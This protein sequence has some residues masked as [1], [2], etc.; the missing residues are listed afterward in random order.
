[1]DDFSDAYLVRYGVEHKLLPEL[2]LSERSKFTILML[3]R[4]QGA[5][6]LHLYGLL[7]EGR[8][9][10][11]PYRPEDFKFAVHSENGE[12]GKPERV[13]LEIITPE[14]EVMPLCSRIYVC[15]DRNLENIEYITLEKS[16]DDTECL[17]GWPSTNCHSNYGRAPETKEAV[18]EK[19]KSMYFRLSSEKGEEQ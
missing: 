10:T 18:L 15:H 1:M 14:P 17:C 2:L 4:T 8:D 16:V 9:Y 5:F 12:D 7:S 11:C 19:V 6:M 13:I 3:A